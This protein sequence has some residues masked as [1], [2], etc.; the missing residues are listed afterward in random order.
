MAPSD[1]GM[2]LQDLAFFTAIRE[3]HY[4]YPVLLSI[5][6]ATLAVIGGAVLVTNLRLLGQAFPGIAIATLLE[7]LRPWKHLGFGLMVTTGGLLAG[8][9]ASDDPKCARPS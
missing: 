1:V 2:G 9:K 4:V 8:S 7:R 6:L 5:H 3:S